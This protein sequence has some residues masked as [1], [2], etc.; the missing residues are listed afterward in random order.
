MKSKIHCRRQQGA[1]E[2]VSIEIGSLFKMCRRIFNLALVLQCSRQVMP[3]TPQL[4][5]EFNC[6]SQCGL[7]LTEALASC[8]RIAERQAAFSA[9]DRKSVV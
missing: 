9:L 3:G 7:G 6:F 5:V 4:G 2:I 8:V 1:D